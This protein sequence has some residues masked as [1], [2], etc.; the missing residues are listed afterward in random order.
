MT[1]IHLH[2][3]C[4]LVADTERQPG[5]RGQEGT[6]QRGDRRQ[7]GAGR[8][9]PLGG[10]DV[11]EGGARPQA[12]S[13]RG[14]YL[15]RGN[16]GLLMRVTFTIGTSSQQKTQGTQQHTY[17]RPLTHTHTHTHT[18]IRPCKSTHAWL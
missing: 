3:I 16:A 18:Y 9:L 10:G 11:Q 7:K 8:R 12:C 17:I 6:V 2:F 14:L 1:D 5:R 15:G 13:T 4:A